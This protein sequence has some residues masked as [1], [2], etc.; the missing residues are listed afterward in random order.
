MHGVINFKR[1]KLTEGWLFEEDGGRRYFVLKGNHLHAFAQK[2]VH[3]V[4]SATEIFDLAV[5]DKV[6]Q[7]SYNKNK[8]SLESTAKNDKRIFASETTKEMLRWVRTI[9]CVQQNITNPQVTF[10]DPQKKARSP[11]MN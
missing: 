5:Y 10:I 4:V 1:P 2:Y 11:Y 6:K 7:V 9:Q 3:D 8:F